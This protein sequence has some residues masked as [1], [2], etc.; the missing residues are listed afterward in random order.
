MA[1]KKATVITAKEAE[2]VSKVRSIETSKGTI[3]TIP[4]VRT[5]YLTTLIIGTAPLIVHSF[6]QK[7]RLK[8]RAKHEGEASAGREPKDC[9]AN[10]EAARYQLSDGSDGIPASGLKACLVAGFDKG[11][12]VAQT[13][14]VGAVRVEADDVLTNLVRL[15]YPKEPKEIAALPHVIN[16]TGRIP[17]CRED[18]V[19]NESGVVDLRHRPEYWPWAVL[20]RI[21]YLPAIASARQVLQAL[22]M[23]GFKNG[24]CEW[25]PTS[26]ESKSGSYGTFRLAT[27]EEVKAFAEGNLF[28]DFVWPGIE[29]LREAAE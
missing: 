2:A 15:I 11:S 22:A 25:R 27:D 16:E 19:R 24:Q 6:S 26:K 10:F 20:V 8:I 9:L 21:Q 4:G 23:S 5:E 14:A 17:R 29:S 7:A 3:V 18:V 28:A 1:A 13:K 12:G